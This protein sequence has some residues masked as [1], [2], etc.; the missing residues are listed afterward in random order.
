MKKLC[1]KYLI[2][3]FFIFSKLKL[4]KNRRRKF[5][6]I[7]WPFETFNSLNRSLSWSITQVF[8][9]SCLEINSIV[10]SNVYVFELFWSLWICEF[11][12]LSFCGYTFII[13]VRL[14]GFRF[15][16]IKMA[17]P[18]PMMSPTC[19]WLFHFQIFLFIRIINMFI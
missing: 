6:T 18:F 19:I 11:L 10:T 17:V 12:K 8:L 14:K 4:V 5:L 9:S 1:L 15:V 16:R 13:W 2:G 7:N 3:P